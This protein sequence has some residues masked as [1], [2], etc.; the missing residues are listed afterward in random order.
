MNEKKKSGC[1]L[2]AALAVIFLMAG[3]SLAGQIY[4][5]GADGSVA[6]RV[7]NG[8]TGTVTWIVGT[9]TSIQTNNIVCDG[10]TNTFLANDALTNGTIALYAAAAAAVTNTSGTASLVINAEPSLAA[11]STIGTILPG[12]YTILPSTWGEIL[13]DTS[14]CKFYSVYFPSRTYQ[15]GVG[16]WRLTNVHGEPTGTGNVTLGIYKG[17]TLYG[18]KVIDS[19]TYSFA[20]TFIT[21]SGGP[22][23]AVTYVTNTMTAVNTVNVDWDVDMPFSGQDAVIIRATRATT[24]TTGILGAIAE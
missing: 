4:A 18:R 14:A 23:D 5:K 17:G 24:A 7:Y 11:D 2:I 13:W 16:A 3:Q 12:T 22:T 1:R 6:L 19:P 10:L 20:S 9:D 21:G 8:Y 15:T